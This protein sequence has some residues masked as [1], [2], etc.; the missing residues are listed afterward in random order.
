[1]LGAMLNSSQD[2]HPCEACW[3][4]PTCEDALAPPLLLLLLPRCQ[5]GRHLVGL[6]LLKHHVCRGSRG[7]QA[8]SLV[9]RSP[10]SPGRDSWPHCPTGSLKLTRLP[11]HAWP[12]AYPAPYSASQP[13][14]QPDILHTL[15]YNDTNTP[16]MGVL[17]STLAR[18]SS[19]ISSTLGFCT[20]AGEQRPV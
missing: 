16:V 9:L 18:S 13:A 4:R 2:M 11:P 12:P 10:T 19:I 15:Q 1:M 8:C 7:W 5:F 3:P 17:A 6:P 20:P 14:R